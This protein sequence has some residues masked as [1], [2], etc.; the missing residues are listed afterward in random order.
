MSPA[1]L[2]KTLA[3]LAFSDAMPA[4]GRGDF[5]LGLPLAKAIAEAHDGTLE[6]RSMPEQGTTATIFLPAERVIVSKSH[7][8]A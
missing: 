4:L 3:P 5:G 2:A 1:F 7:A 8:A 6:L